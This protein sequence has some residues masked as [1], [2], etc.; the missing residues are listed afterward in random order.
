[1]KRP[2]N[3]TVVPAGGMWKY[4]D[5]VIGVPASS[6]SLTVMLQQVKAQRLANGLEVESGWDDAVLD[7]MCEQNP[8]FRCVDVGVPEIHLTGDDV[9]RFLVTL[10]ELYGNELVSDE[11]HRRRADIC[12]SCPKMADVACT[13]PCGWVSKKLTE[14]LGGRKIHRPAE[15]HKKGCSACKCNLDAKTYYPLEVL[16]MVDQKLGKQPEYWSNCWM[17]ES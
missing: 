2:F 4:T 7:E 13:F 10:Q 14:M 9:K 17:R 3:E 6:N 16:K 15:L 1:M 8:G 11:E 12:L 5:P